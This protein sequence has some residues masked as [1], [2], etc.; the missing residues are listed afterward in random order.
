MST[1]FMLMN[2]LLFADSAPAHWVTNKSNA[3]SVPVRTPYMWS[4]FETSDSISGT[5]GSVSDYG[6]A[7]WVY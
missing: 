4:A 7:A 3:L 2:E 5:S 6:A 1:H